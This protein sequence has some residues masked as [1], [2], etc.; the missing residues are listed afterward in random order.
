MLPK[1]STYTRSTKPE[2]TAEQIIDDGLAAIERRNALAESAADFRWAL[3]SGP[4]TPAPSPRVA[5]PQITR[6]PAPPSRRGKQREP[7][8]LPPDAVR[9]HIRSM[10]PRP[11]GLIALL[12]LG[13]VTSRSGRR[14]TMRCPSHLT[15]HADSTPS[16][17]IST[18]NGAVVFGCFG[19]K[20]SGDVFGLI[21]LAKGFDPKTQFPKVLDAAARLVG[22]GSADDVRRA[23]EIGGVL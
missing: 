18:K 15:G 7:V 8:Y 2:L 14:L 22:Y 13:S 5:P 4:N 11:D 6:L 12:G 21:G 10:L 19:C 20:I 17:G 3:T 23:L 9:E 1:A 16:F